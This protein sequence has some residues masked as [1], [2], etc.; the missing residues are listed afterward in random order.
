MFKKSLIIVLYFL[1][2][3]N[4]SFANTEPICKKVIP[5]NHLKS[6]DNQLPQKIEIEVNNNRKWLKHN[7][8]MIKN[9]LEHDTGGNIII[10]PKY[11]KKFK[12]TLHVYFNNDIKCSFQSKVRQHGDFLDHIELINGNLYQS[13]DVSL[14]TGNIN[15]ITKFKLLIPKTRNN[16]EDE[17]FFTELLRE[18]GYLAPRTG[19]V[20]IKYN[21]LTKTMLF[22]EKAE[23]EMLEYNLRREGPILEGDERFMFSIEYK[24]SYGIITT[25]P[26]LTRQTN[27]KWALKSSQHENISHEAITL[28]NLFYL[29]SRSSENSNG[30]FKDYNLNIL[31]SNLLVPNNPQQVLSMD[32]YNAIIFSVN[33]SHSLAQ[34]NKKIYWNSINNFFE[35]IYYDG[36]LNIDANYEN[37]DFKLNNLPNKKSF[38]YAIEEA[39]NKIK[40]IDRQKLANRIDL[41]GS[42][43]SLKE[44]NKKLNQMTLNL[45]KLK[46]HVIKKQDQTDQELINNQDILNK[47]ADYTEDWGFDIY[48]VFRDVDTKLFYACKNNR[49]NCDKINLSEKQIKDLLR[50]RLK[51]NK[52]PYQYIG[53]FKDLLDII[54]SFKLNDKKLSKHQKIKFKDTNFYFNEGIDYKYDEENSVFDV[55]QKKPGARAYF[56]GGEL[57]DMTINFYGI[58]EDIYGNIYNYPF[59]QNGLTGCL[60][61]IKMKLN[62]ISISSL[63]SD[64]ED[65]INLI[66]STGNIKNFNSSNSYKDGLDIDFSNIEIDYVKVFSSRN[67]CVD[68]SAGIYKINK[69]DLKNCGDKGLSV[70]EKSNLQLNEIF[71][72]NSNIGIASKDSSVTKLNNAYLK[73]LKTCL[74]AYNKK[75]EFFGGLIEIQNINCENY[76]KK[77]ETDIN[78]KIIIENEL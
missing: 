57:K 39:K 41:R 65:S 73:N 52:V 25:Q 24:N 32:V 11:K 9:T 16:P 56:L 69:L 77:I 72:E 42:S 26:S 55:F 17:I 23:K 13:L 62:N 53:E 14:L 3:C 68:F 2:Y 31:N 30:T 33:G 54:T 37:Y 1:L 74:S 60:S 59:D 71:I 64:C 38:L 18:F 4:S 8:R 76:S 46:A 7:L 51:I 61:F 40:Q 6:I 27:A 10:A 75:Q 78:S 20:K 66:N 36:D 35:P 29:K 63:N 45:E 21:N 12:A 50:G 70:G 48:L 15:G 22:Q 34:R 67:D 19:F 47:Y 43:L 28:F 5:K 58:S 49:K 44:V